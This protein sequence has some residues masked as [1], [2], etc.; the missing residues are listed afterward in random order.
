MSW[1]GRSRMEK[2]GL[3]SHRR[4]AND[5]E[6]CTVV[7]FQCLVGEGHQRNVCDLSALQTF[8]A[9]PLFRASLTYPTA[10]VVAMWARPRGQGSRARACETDSAS[11]IIFWDA[12]D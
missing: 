9:R 8:Y 5:D 1:R 6:G 10:S 7:N 11:R 2:G 3:T 12:V 4:H